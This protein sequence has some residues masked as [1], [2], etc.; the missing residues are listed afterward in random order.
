[1]LTT[2]SYLLLLL[3]HSLPGSLNG[4]QSVHWEAWRVNVS[5]LRASVTSLLGGDYGIGTPHPAIPLHGAKKA[6]EYH[7]DGMSRKRVK[8]SIT[9]QSS[10]C[11]RGR[12]DPLCLL[13]TSSQLQGLKSCPSSTEDAP[14]HILHPPSTL[15]TLP[16]H[17]LHPP[18]H[19]VTPQLRLLT[20]RTRRVVLTHASTRE[21]LQTVALMI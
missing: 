9:S 3:L 2:H 20:H 7:T 14:P 4:L 18:L 21:S 5:I 10:G 17:T 15:Y 1:M 13:S 8:L 6:T 19:P 11:L 12:L 16:L